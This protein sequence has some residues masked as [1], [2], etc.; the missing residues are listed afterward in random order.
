[1]NRGESFREYFRRARTDPGVRAHLLENARY[2]R[3]AMG[4]VA[5]VFAAL[6]I[7]LSTYEGLHGR[8]WMP[9]TSMFCAVSCVI[10][11]LIYDKFGD[12]IAILS[13][14]DDAPGQ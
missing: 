8:E 10:N 1:M 2:S 5:L 9:P 6:G 3:S 11:V 12:R 13:S 4:W 7:G 14:M